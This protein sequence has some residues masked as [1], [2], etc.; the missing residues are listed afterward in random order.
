MQVCLFSVFHRTR[1]GKVAMDR[2]DRRELLSLV[3]IVAARIEGEPHSVDGWERVLS[4]I[5]ELE[6]RTKDVLE[7][8]VK[9]NLVSKENK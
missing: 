9:E 5:S 8:I 6:D 1:T 2:K 4:S 3:H 7:K